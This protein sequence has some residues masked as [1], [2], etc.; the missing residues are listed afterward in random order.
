MAE[1]LGALTGAIGA[2]GIHP[3]GAVFVCG[4]RETTILKAKVGAKFDHPVLTTLGL[5]AKT[6]ACFAPDG[7]A[8]G[9]QDAPQIETSKEAVLHM[10]DTTPADIVSAGGVLA[11]PSKSMFQT[12]IIA[13]RVRAHC[14][15]AVA[16]GAAQVVTSVN[17]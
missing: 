16:A 1:D 7:V 10:E 8:S 3:N 17:W 11:A 2:A 12:D 4:P 14:A 9:Y 13:I 6:V 15:W 5:P